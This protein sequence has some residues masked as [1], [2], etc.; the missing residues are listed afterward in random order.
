MT[1]KPSALAQQYLAALRQFLK[2][3]KT[4]DLEPAR[5]LGY[6]ALA[7]KQET[8]DLARIHENALIKLDKLGTTAAAR[9]DVIRRAGMFFAEAIT[10][11]EQTH[12]A[13][14][15]ANS[16]LNQVVTELNQR[17][18]ELA[19]S[20][21]E[22]KQ[23]IAQRKLVEESLRTSEQTSSQL[24]E[25]S[26]ELQGE[27]RRLSRQLLS[28]QEEERRK[29]SREL[30]DVIAQTLSGINVKLASL[31]AESSASA[32][33]I[34]R[35]IAATQRMV[36]KSVDIVHRFARELR[37]TVLDDLGLIP[38][39]KAFMQDYTTNTGV[40]V[41]L[42]AAAGVEHLEGTFCTILYRVAQESLTNVARHAKA[43]RVDVSIMESKGVVTMAITDD[44]CGFQVD[45][46]S[47]ALGSNRLGLLGMR[48]RVEMVNGTFCVDSSP[49]QPTT[50]HVEIPFVKACIPILR[51]RSPS[52][53]PLHCK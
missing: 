7:W 42:K 12:R 27:L 13:A 10:P 49:G 47:R 8:L 15:D 26:R 11:L 41:S 46:A 4:A 23:E 39:L 38:A 18:V 2:K 5:K 32:K 9:R 25:K 22:L 51:K 24:L 31:T 53:K 28:A 14:R 19:S 29:I 3:G 21:V 6:Q 33:D 37:P 20:V 17:T 35:K 45:G 16:N 50:V 1:S 44:G 36:L 34:Q 48:E 40:R 52:T 30:H 43:S